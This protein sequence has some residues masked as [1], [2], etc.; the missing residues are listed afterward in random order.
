MSDIASLNPV[1]AEHPPIKDSGTVVT[2]RRRIPGLSIQEPAFLRWIDTAAT[3]ERL[4]YHLGHLG[5]DRVRGFSDLPEPAREELGR[6]ADL[7]MVGA[8]EGSLRLVQRR[9]DQDRIG[10]RRAR[11]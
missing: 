3:G 5:V 11:S 1:C 4:T 9:V 8:E 10:G 7:A 2:G 6:I